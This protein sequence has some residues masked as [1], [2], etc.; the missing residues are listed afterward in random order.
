M[1]DENGETIYTIEV[2]GVVE[3][4]CKYCPKAYAPSGGTAVAASHDH[5]KT[6]LM[7]QLKGPQG[8][9]PASKSVCTHTNTSSL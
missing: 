7:R 5:V 9:S 1:P 8:E 2:S 4:C 6:W 3:W